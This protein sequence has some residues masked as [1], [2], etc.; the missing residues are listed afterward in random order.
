M[1]PQPQPF[2]YYLDVLKNK[3]AQFNG[4]ARRREYWYFVL[5][6]LLISIG[7]GIVGTFVD[8]NFL[9]MIY[10]LAVFVP[11]I[12]AAVRRLHDT[13]RSGL[14]ILIG[15]IPVLGLIVLIVFMVEDS[16]PDNQYGPNPKAAVL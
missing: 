4:R 9:S 5:F 13:G 3:Y 15:L 2:D 12:A 8:S 14:W 11:G 16:K 7:L 1:N 10:N 6:N